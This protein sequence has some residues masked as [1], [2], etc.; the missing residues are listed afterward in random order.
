MFR[1]FSVL[2][3]KLTVK[4]TA[5]EESKQEHGTCN[6]GLMVMLQKE[7]VYVTPLLSVLLWYCASARFRI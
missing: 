1:V 5:I 2:L 3:L 7:W 4:I 6:L